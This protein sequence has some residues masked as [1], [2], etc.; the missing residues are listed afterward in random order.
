MHLWFRFRRTHV[1][2]LLET[3]AAAGKSCPGIAR[4]HSSCKLKSLVIPVLIGR[5]FPNLTSFTKRMSFCVLS[6]RTPQHPDIFKKRVLQILFRYISTPVGLLVRLT[7]RFSFWRRLWN[8][9]WWLMMT[10]DWWLMTNDS[11]LM[12][13]DRALGKPHYKHCQRHNA[14]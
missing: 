13:G 14:P 1:Y 3:S 12:T 11:W 2:C 5:I 8:D 6:Q 7:Y 10:D 4:S 9:D